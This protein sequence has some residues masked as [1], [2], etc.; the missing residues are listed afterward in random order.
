MFVL[1]YAPDRLAREQ[2]CRHLIDAGNYQCLIAETMRLCVALAL[3]NEILLTLLFEPHNSR[4]MID[5]KDFLREKRRKMRVRILPDTN[6]VLMNG[7]RDVVT[8]S[9]RPVKSRQK[10]TWRAHPRFKWTP[11]TNFP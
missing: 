1:I 9:L 7:W 5:L 10:S 6:G 8:K 11:P 3:H 2:I 4:A